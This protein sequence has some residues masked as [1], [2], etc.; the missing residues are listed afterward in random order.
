[1]PDAHVI[2]SPAVDDTISTNG[3]LD[4][5]WTR[6]A[7]SSEAWIDTKDWTTTS[8]ADNGSGKVPKGHNEVNSNQSVGVT[9]RNNVNPAG[10]ASGSVMHASVRVSVEPVIVQ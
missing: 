8:Q 4:V 1:M 2:T 6:S 7:A 10:M 3:S 5:T 9:R